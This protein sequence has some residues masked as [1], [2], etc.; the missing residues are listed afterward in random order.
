MKLLATFALPEA[1]ALTQKPDPP[2]KG[3]QSSRADAGLC[4][5]AINLAPSRRRGAV[6]IAPIKEKLGAVC[7][8][9]PA[10][11]GPS[12]RLRLW[13][14]ATSVHLFQLVYSA[15]VDEQIPS[16]EN[17]NAAARPH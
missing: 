7:V 17:A 2:Q 10:R 3:P 11:L 8:K 6:I 15:V 4:F 12:P 14:A 16:S 1:E 13:L 9:W 5:C